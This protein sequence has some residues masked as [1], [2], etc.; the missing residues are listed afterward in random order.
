MELFYVKLNLAFKPFKHLTFLLQFK[1]SLWIGLKYFYWK[2][3]ILKWKLNIE[4][5]LTLLGTS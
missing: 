4:A 2:G 1:V 3:H 5:R